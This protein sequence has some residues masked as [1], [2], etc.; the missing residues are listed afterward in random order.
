MRAPCT[1][2]ERSDVTCLELDLFKSLDC[3][4]LP[5]RLKRRLDAIENLGNGRAAA[6]G[7]SAARGEGYWSTILCFAPIKRYKVPE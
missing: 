1:L 6:E 3:D 7:A 4:E 2:T 5:R